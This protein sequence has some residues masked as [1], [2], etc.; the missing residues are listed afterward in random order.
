MYSIFSALQYMHNNNIVHRDLKPENILIS[1]DLSEIK[2]SDFGLSTA[3][4][5]LMT[6]QCGT[7]TYMAPE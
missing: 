4:S 7:L 3:Y 6:K 2:V 1:Q 5:S